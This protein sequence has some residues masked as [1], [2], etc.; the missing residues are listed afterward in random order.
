VQRL[1]GGPAAAEAFGWRQDMD[2][3]DPA[4]GYMVPAWTPRK[5]DNIAIW[6]Q[7]VGDFMK[8]DF[9]GRL[10][11]ETQHLY[12][13]VFDALDMQ[14]QQ[15]KMQMMAQEQGAAAQLGQANAAAPQLPRSV[16]A[17]LGRC[18]LSRR[19]RRR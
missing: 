15:R 10:P 19:R 3:G 16:A 1:K 14:E 11:A 17:G 4:L 2:F 12:D 7:V 6:K 13:T 18:R 9:Y 8:T 5:V